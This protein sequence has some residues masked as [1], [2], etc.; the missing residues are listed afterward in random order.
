[1]PELHEYQKQAV[2]YVQARKTAGLFLDMGLG[3]TCITLSAFTP[4]SLPALVTA[5]KRVAEEVW[6]VE[7]P[8]WRPDL[9]VKVAAGSPKQRKQALESNADIIVI[10]RDNIADALPYAHKFRSLVLD[11]LSGYKSTK[12]A[13]YKVTKKI[14]NHA[15]IEY[16]WGLTGTPQPKDMMDLFGQLYILD[17][18]KRLGR[19]ITSYRQGYFNPGKRIANGTVVEWDLQEGAEQAI[20][21]KI[22][23]I[24]LSMDTEG[25]VKLPE[26]TYNYVSVPLPPSVRRLYKEFKK[27][28]VLDIEFLGEVYSAG[29]AAILSSRLEQ[30]TA[31]FLYPDD[32]T[33]DETF[34]EYRV[35]HTEKA[36]ALQEI[37]DGT[38]GGVLVSYRFRAELEI[39]KKALGKQA[40]TIDEPDVIARWNRGEI[41]VLLAHP[42]SAGHGLNLQFG[43]HTMVWATSPWSLEEYQQ[44]NKRLHRQG[45]THPVIIHHLESPHTVDVVKRQRLQQRK[46]AQQALL[47]HLASPL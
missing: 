36:T 17:G 12:T 25:R 18:G 10:G 5:P 29:N 8:K 32:M 2:G 42:Q 4:D 14:R 39:L 23:D 1:M 45:Q 15:N 16:V 35:L 28:L 26:V 33:L 22:A 34:D 11:E 9:T 46:T 21:S 38:S 7:V 41:P 30:I 27:E 13:R 37:I 19:T 24:C 6:P 44:M 43:G 3:K 31:G 40:H 20:R 47:D